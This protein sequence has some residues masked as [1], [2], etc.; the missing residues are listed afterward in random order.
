MQ[1]KPYFDQPYY[2]GFTVA[3]FELGLDPNAAPIG[4]I[5]A[6][7][8]AYWRVGDIDREFD[9]LLSLGGREH[10]KPHD[11]GDGMK[12]AIVI[13]PFNNLLGLYYNPHEAK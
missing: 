4:N 6:G 11:V 3:G 8:V 10:E 5:S 9:K 7:V 1:I 2:V 13:D 12:T